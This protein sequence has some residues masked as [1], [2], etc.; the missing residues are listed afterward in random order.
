MAKKNSRNLPSPDK[1]MIS[2]MWDCKGV[3]LVDKNAAR[4]DNK[5]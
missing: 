3:I 4:G 1:T 2:V 5:L